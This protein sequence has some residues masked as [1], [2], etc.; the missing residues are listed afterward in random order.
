MLGL[1]KNNSNKNIVK[2]DWEYGSEEDFDK[3]FTKFNRLDDATDN[4]IEGTGLGL[5][6]T[7]KYVDSMGGKI[8]FESEYGAGT[9]FFIEL[10]QRIVDTSN[11]I[12]R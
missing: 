12:K 3:M 9:T 1:R 5:V 6:I 4:A 11:R 7:K 10:P 2:L 8:W